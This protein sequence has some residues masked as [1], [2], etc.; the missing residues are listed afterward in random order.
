MSQK[1]NTW[2]GLV[3]VGVAAAMLAVGF[4]FV[5]LYRMFC[6]AFGIPVPA[7]LVG[8]AAQYKGPQEAGGQ[9]GRTVLVRFTANVGQGMPAKFTPHDFSLR[10]PLGTPVL[11]AYEAVN[12]GMKDLD[13]VAVHM[14]Y[15]M[16]GDGGDVGKYVELQQCFCFELQHYPAGET[17]MLPLS[18]LLTSD[19]PKEIHTITF[20]YTLFE[21]MPNDPRLKDNH[22]QEEEA[23]T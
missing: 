1:K 16:G 13:G 17:K 7:V 21:A 2:M 9:S 22:G 5:P 3:L 6:Q 15:A 23:K 14:L 12:T 19:L 10:V 8:E 20:S 18:F 4:A 11:T